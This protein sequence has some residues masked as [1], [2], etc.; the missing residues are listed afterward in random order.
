M[1]TPATPS[2]AQ[3]KAALHQW[4]SIEKFT[5]HDAALHQLFYEFCPGNDDLAQVLLKVSTL[6]SFYSTNIYNSLA[7]ARHIVALK[8]GGRFQ[9][10]DL[11]LVN[12]LAQVTVGGK[13]RN[14]YSFATKYCSHHNAKDF[15]I[16][17]SYVDKMLWHFARR[18]EFAKFRRKEL[19]QYERFVEVIHAFQRHYGLQQFSLKQIDMYLWIAGKA[20]FSVYSK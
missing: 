11:S 9:K 16:Y 15:P 4:D 14:F 13:T 2:S 7:V 20:A 10:G 6:N 5:I 3:V 8:V 17:D 1:K 12:D 19:R 18:D